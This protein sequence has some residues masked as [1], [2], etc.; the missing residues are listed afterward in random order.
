MQVSQLLAK[1]NSE[2]Q[3]ELI[4]V[5]KQILGVEQVDEVK[6][7]ATDRLGI[8]LRVKVGVTKY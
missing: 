4:L 8:D 3:A 5:C 2:R 1:V 6:L 7:V